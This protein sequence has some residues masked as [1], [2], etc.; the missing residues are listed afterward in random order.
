M[1]QAKITELNLL[2]VSGQNNDLT[3]AATSRK[4]AGD[5]KK[6]LP[7]LLERL[8]RATRETGKMS[9][10]ADYLKAPLASVSRWLSGKREPG[11][12][13]ALQMLHWVEQ[14]ERQK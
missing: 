8:N 14:Q 7:S 9:A 4:L 3:E 5:V 2:A 12:E 11:G 10:L 1:N 13:T 6:Q